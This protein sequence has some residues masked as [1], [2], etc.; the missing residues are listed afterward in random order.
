MTVSIYVTIANI[1]IVIESGS[2]VQKSSFEQSTN[3]IFFTT[4]KEYFGT[5]R[6]KYTPYSL[7]METL[8]R[9][10]YDKTISSEEK[11]I[12]V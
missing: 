8:L 12:A 1:S 7:K 11:C 10:L 4:P 9:N 5:E 3:V 2:I 6:S